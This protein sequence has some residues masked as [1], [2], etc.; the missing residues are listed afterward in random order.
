MVEVFKT[1]VTTNDEAKKLIDLIHFSFNHYR[2]NFD[3][4]DCD[5]ILRIKCESEPIE[6]NLILS[7]FNQYGF[8][9]EVLMDDFEL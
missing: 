7:I 6:T 9:A 1:D 4:D 3:L 8:N 5:R 2:A